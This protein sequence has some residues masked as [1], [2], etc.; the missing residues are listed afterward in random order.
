[1]SLAYK[2]FGAVRFFEKGHRKGTRLPQLGPLP[3]KGC[4]LFTVSVIRNVEFDALQQKFASR[5]KIM[6]DTNKSL[7]SQ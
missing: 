1:M 2:I 4:V 3:F 5:M 6:E 7:H